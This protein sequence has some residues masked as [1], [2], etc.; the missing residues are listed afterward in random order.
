M[1]IGFSEI[2]LI[3]VV[4]LAL[5]KPEKL[6]EYS[7][8]MGKTLRTIKAEK[9][10]AEE[11]FIKPIKDDIDSVKEDINAIKEPIDEITQPIKDVKNLING[12]KS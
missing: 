12:P 4:A 2:I 11:Q 10:K 1:R 6:K 8:T 9:D 7:K 3:V 5:I